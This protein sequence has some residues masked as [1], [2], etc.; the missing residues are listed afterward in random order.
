M[1]LK[2]NILILFIFIFFI[3]ISGAYSAYNQENINSVYDNVNT[4]DLSDLM[5]CCSI[6]WQIDENHT[7]FSYRRDANFSADIHIEQVDWHGKT[8]IKQYK[9]DKGYFCHVIV[10][11]DGWVIGLGGIDDGK[12]SAKCENISAKMVCEDHSISKSKLKEIQEIKAAHGRGHVLIKAP[13]GTY[14][15]ATPSKI[16]MGTLKP[17]RYI[18]MPNDYSFSRGDTLSVKTPDKIKAMNNLAQTDLYGVDRREVVSYDINLGNTSNTTDIYVSNED[19]S[20][21]G[22]DYLNLID[23][24]YVNNTHIKGKDIPVAPDYDKIASYHFDNPNPMIYNLVVLGLILGVIVLVTA[25][26]F[27]S[28]KIVKSVK[29]KFRR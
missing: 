27:V 13:N 20:A 29:Y 2:R 18:S 3:L 17:G 19:G 15:F 8:A 14:G 9:E 23:D 11:S 25:V 16:K 7:M 28:Y 22:R 4:T 21:V 6:V 10:T 12:D 24:V 1:N 5:G 26:T